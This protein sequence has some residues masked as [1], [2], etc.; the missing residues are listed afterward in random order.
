M[1]ASVTQTASWLTLVG[2]LLGGLGSAV[3]AWFALK[4]YQDLVERAQ[5]PDFLKV[6]LRFTIELWSTPRAVG[7]LLG[8]TLGGMVGV[9]L[10]VPVRALFNGRKDAATLA[11]RTWKT[12]RA[13]SKEAFLELPPVALFRAQR[14][15]ARNLG[16]IRASGKDDARRLGE[17]A[18]Q[19]FSWSMVL[20]GAILVSI[21]SAIRLY[22]AYQ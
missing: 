16:V 14:V 20:L 1:P 2:G 11:T 4:E 7:S 18:N 13:Q 21:S 3:R 12:M 10:L 9:L 15:V 8:I 22:W 19:A 17:L 5:I 6:A